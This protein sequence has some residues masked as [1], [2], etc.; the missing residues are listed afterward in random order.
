[1]KGITVENFVPYLDHVHRFCEEMILELCEKSKNVEQTKLNMSLD[2]SQPSSF[3]RKLHNKK[4]L[5]LSLVY[6][7]NKVVAV[8]AIEKYDDKTLCILKRLAVIKAYRFK[9][10]TSNFIL[11]QQIDWA[12]NNGWK[13]V[14]FSFNKYNKVI[15]KLMERMNQGNG[16]VTTHSELFNKFEY[17]GLINIQ[18]TEQYTYEYILD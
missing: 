16:V 2:L 8:S 6:D 11:P 1:M 18:N 15:G 17:I 7:N 3:L 13:K 14:W 5:A 10:A 9:P 12:I 4:Y